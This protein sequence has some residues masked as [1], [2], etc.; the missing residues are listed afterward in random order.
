MEVGLRNTNPV[1]HLLLPKLGLSTVSLLGH[2]E[3]KPEELTA[4]S[5]S[6]GG[7]LSMGISSH[8]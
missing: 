6:P 2:L 7:Y 1:L 8:K 4:L 5:L 3:F